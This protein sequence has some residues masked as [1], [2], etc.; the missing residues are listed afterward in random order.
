M[1]RRIEAAIF[2]GFTL[3]AASAMRPRDEQI[4]SQPPP[5]PTPIIR[6][7]PLSTPTPETILTRESVEKQFGVNL[8]TLQ[9]VYAKNGKNIKEDYP[10][11][12]SYPWNTYEISWTQEKL[13]MTSNF[14]SRLPKSLYQSNENGRLTI[15]MGAEFL[16][17]DYRITN[18]PRNIQLDASQF[19]LDGIGMERSF[20]LFTHEISHTAIE[21]QEVKEDLKKLL[22]KDFSEIHGELD[23]RYKEKELLGSRFY[24]SL[25]DKEGFEFV[26]IMAELYLKGPKH[27]TQIYGEFFP[28]TTVSNLYDYIRKRF[29]EDKEY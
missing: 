1:S 6:E 12:T 21:P 17:Q 5:S 15:V 19:G 8:T 10:K 24:Y 23:K 20:G 2:A 25:M 11:L 26:A 27:F 18:P 7:T 4:G 13:I 29:F 28:P 9:E 3:L 14:L 22:G 16:A